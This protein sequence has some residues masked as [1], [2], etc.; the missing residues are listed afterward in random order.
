MG[1]IAFATAA[2]TVCVCVTVELTSKSLGFSTSVDNSSQ[3]A[4]FTAKL[5]G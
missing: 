3:T 5:D 1:E 2:T 4:S